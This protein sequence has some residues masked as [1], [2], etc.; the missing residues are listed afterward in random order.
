LSSSP[1]IIGMTKS[2][3]MLWAEDVARRGVRGM[4]TGFWWENRKE[5]DC[6]KHLD[7]SGRII[8]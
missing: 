7:V 5:R 3:M 6:Y 2:R 8:Y 1:N 4:H